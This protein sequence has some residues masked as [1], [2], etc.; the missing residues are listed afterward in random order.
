MRP[1]PPSRPCI[2]RRARLAFVPGLSLSYQERILRTCG[3]SS[4]TTYLPFLFLLRAAGLWI[5]RGRRFFKSAPLSSQ[6]AQTAA[7]SAA[8]RRSQA[9]GRRRRIS[10]CHCRAISRSGRTC[11]ASPV[12]TTWF[13]FSRN[14]ACTRS[15]RGPQSRM[16]AISTCRCD[17]LAA[18]ISAANQPAPANAAA[19]GALS[20]VTARLRSAAAETA[21]FACDKEWTTKNARSH[22]RI[23]ALCCKHLSVIVANL[24]AL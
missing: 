18:R 6:A 8:W 15:A 4:M 23:F 19:P 9:F 14:A 13:N 5:A 1:V 20:S 7:G 2:S 24:P 21:A 11:L 12:K 17:S 10:A 3:V 16:P 22:R